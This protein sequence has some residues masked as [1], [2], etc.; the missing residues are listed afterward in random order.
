MGLDAMAY[1]KA[2]LTDP[3][4]PHQDSCYDNSHVFAF[5]LEGQ[6]H[7]LDGLEDERCYIASGE[8]EH[9]NQSYGNY[10]RYRE[11]LC[12][13]VLGVDPREVWESPEQY[14]DKPF[15]HQI[16]FA[17]NEGVIGPVASAKLAKDY[18]ERREEFIEGLPSA[19]QHFF[20]ED[21]LREFDGA[22]DYYSR[23]YEEW[24]RMFEIAA[25]TGLVDYH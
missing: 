3:H 13:A 21:G 4:E 6:Q 22:L 12:Y 19:V 14:A 23:K 11:V 10:N 1:E 7:A 8:S 5:T 17:D 18:E 15:Y 20:G 24:Q 2:E 25:D 16:N 9:L